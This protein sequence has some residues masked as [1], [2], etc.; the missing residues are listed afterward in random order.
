[1]QANA[2]LNTNITKHDYKKIRSS[3]GAAGRHEL[4]CTKFTVSMIA[5]FHQE[6][7]EQMRDGIRYLRKICE[8][9]MEVLKE[10]FALR[11][12]NSWG[13]VV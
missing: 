8:F 1:M 12:G 13:I 3:I 2:P 11:L 4:I 7:V 10:S 6:V 9:P 5:G